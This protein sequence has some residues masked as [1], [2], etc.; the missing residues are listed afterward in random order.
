MESNRGVLD[1]PSTIVLAVCTIVAVL[2]TAMEAGDMAAGP[3]TMGLGLAGFLGIWVVMIAAMMLPAVSPVASLYL[4]RLSAEPRPEIRALRTASL[5]A[6]YLTAWA[7]FGF[8]AF[9]LAALGGLLVEHAPDEAPYIAA[10]GLALAGVY[11]LTPLKNF[12][13]T[14][15]RSPLAL[16]LRYSGIKGRARDFRVGLHHGAFCVGC[17]W[18]LMLVLVIVGV[19]NLAW[20]LVI[21]CTVLLEKTWRQGRQFSLAVGVALIV[22]AFAVPSHPG[23]APGL[24]PEA[25]VMRM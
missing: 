12:C 7:A 4:Q 8:V 18:G 13:L 15:C 17:C 3:G 9:G 23:W 24:Q 2:V 19:M 5:V 14:Q 16:F 10:G 1:S 25:P 20:M 21:A 22:F 11:Q 6:G